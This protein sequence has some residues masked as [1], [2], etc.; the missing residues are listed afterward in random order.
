MV[1][2]DRTQFSLGKLLAFVTGL[3]AVLVILLSIPDWW[4]IATF[5]AHFGLYITPFLMIGIPM[6]ARRWWRMKT[7]REHI[8]V[9]REIALA[10]AHAAAAIAARKK[11]R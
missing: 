9:E 5:A 8:V 3:A 11:G 7:Q 2:E 10:Q 6:I 1:S 4:A